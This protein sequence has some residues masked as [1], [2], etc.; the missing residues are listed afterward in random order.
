MN[1]IDWWWEAWTIACAIILGSISL[2][3][4]LLRGKPPVKRFIIAWLILGGIGYLVI[5]ITS[6]L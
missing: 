4:L 1:P 6:V 2:A 3:M 5:F